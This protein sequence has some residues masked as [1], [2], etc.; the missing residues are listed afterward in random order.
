MVLLVFLALL[1]LVLVGV[2]G[3]H[4]RRTEDFH[5]ALAIRLP[6]RPAIL[7]QLLLH[8]FNFTVH[9]PP[10]SVVAGC[11]GSPFSHALFGVLRLLTMGGSSFTTAISLSGDVAHCHCSP[12]WQARLGAL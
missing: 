1:A 5:P 4:L 7:L 2:H 11:R 9:I 6:L 3:R 12:V 8:N 10:S